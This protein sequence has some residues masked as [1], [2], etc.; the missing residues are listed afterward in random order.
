M[1][2]TLLYSDKNFDSYDHPFIFASVSFFVVPTRAWLL[3]DSISAVKYLVFEKK[4]YSM[5]QVVEA[6]KAEWK[7]F[8][9]MRRDFKEAPKFGNND[10]FADTIMQKVVTDIHNVSRHCL[11]LQNQAIF[12][13]ALV[14]TWMYHL[15]PLTGALPNG[16]KRGEP[17]CDGGINPHAEF[18]KGGHWDRL[19]SAMSVDQ[20]K[21]KAWIYNQKFDYNSVEG[22]T[23]LDKLV[24][25][26]MAG[27][28]GG[29]SQLQYNMV[30]RDLL[31]DAKKNPEKYPYL[32]VRI[33]GYSAY[34]T[35]L[36]E[37][38]QDAVIQRVDNE[39]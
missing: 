15:A 6:L 35:S 19:N 13:H 11:D 33:S 28:E 27:L 14:V 37:Y 30:S 2:Q 34:F 29:M 12:P 5:A 32:S 22:D 23:G 21:L 16:R 8:D 26:S 10:Q 38:V 9:D 25:F 17:L 1:F 7:G 36:P 18:D 3:V 39:L 31:V 4:K 20:T 24:D